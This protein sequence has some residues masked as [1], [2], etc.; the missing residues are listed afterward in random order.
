MGVLTVHIFI[1][2]YLVLRI[3]ILKMSDCL[4]LI[5]TVLPESG[6]LLIVRKGQLDPL[7]RN[8]RC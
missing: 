8:F 5:L 4:L 3:L 6:Q 1:I 7:C 2:V